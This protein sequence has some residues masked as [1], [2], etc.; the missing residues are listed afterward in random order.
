MREGCEIVCDGNSDDG[1]DDDD[2]DDDD[3]DI[4]DDDDD[5][6]MNGNDVDDQNT[7]YVVITTD[8]MLKMGRTRSFSV[9]H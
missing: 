1:D 2:D 8:M 4:D 9:K 3:I 5:D 7:R 6:G